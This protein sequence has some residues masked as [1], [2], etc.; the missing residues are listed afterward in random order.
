MQNDDPWKRS[1]FPLRVFRVLALSLPFYISVPNPS[2]GNC[3]AAAISHVR[4][5]IRSPRASALG[6]ATGPSLRGSVRLGRLRGCQRSPA[7]RPTPRS[8]PCTGQ[9]KWA[10]RV[11]LAS[12]PTTLRISRHTPTTKTRTDTHSRELTR[13]RRGK[14]GGGKSTTG[15]SRS[16][17]SRRLKKVGWISPKPRPGTSLQTAEAPTLT[18]REPLPGTCPSTASRQITQQVYFVCFTQWSFVG[19]SGIA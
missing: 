9:D 10:P 2:Y 19:S 16:P 6:P 11:F 1:N 3:T 15:E 17:S 18:L 5:Q 12:S 14:E 7:S 13:K 4:R 8:S